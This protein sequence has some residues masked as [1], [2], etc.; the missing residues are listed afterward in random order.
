MIITIVIPVY[1]TEK[2]LDQCIESVRVQTYQEWEIIAID[3]GSTDASLE[4]LKKYRDLDSRIIIHEQSNQGAGPARN[5][6]IKNAQGDYIAFLDSDDYWADERCLEKLV[7][8]LAEKEY[9]PIAGTYLL[10]EQDGVLSE[11]PIHKQ[12]ITSINKESKSSLKKSRKFSFIN[13]IYLKQDF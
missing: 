4:I 1:N 13:H 9:P 3:D 12:Y 5:Y 8:F 6:G 11:H 2:Y 7:F 10:L